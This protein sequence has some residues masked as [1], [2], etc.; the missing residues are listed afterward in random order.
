MNC[1]F[2]I[3]DSEIAKYQFELLSVSPDLTCLA[4]SLA[5]NHLFLVNLL[6][7][8]QACVYAHSFTTKGHC[9]F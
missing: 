6:D 7:Y 3:I 2:D 9:I 1:L 8:Y 4:V 5:T